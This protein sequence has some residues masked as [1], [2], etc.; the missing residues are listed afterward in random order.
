MSVMSLTEDKDAS[1]LRKIDLESCK[2]AAEFLS[3][4]EERGILNQN[5]QQCETYA[6]DF[7]KYLTQILIPK[8]L[9]QSAEFRFLYRRVYKTGSYYDGLRIVSDPRNTE[10]DINIVLSLFTP[11][12]KDY[13]G[14]EN[15]HIT[16][17]EHVPSGFVKITCDEKSI[18]RLQQKKGQKF[19]TKFHF[20][21]VENDKSPKAL[22]DNETEYFLH[23]KKTRV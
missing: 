19:E 17:N 7:L 10:L 21:R 18:V 13:V 9:E 23:P 20:K 12:I 6:N 1:L 2:D 14:A 8:M 22:S 4:L 5:A 11:F 15:I 16:N 3:R